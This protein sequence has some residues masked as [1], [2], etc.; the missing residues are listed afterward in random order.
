[1]TSANF[2]NF[3]DFINHHATY[4]DPTVLLVDLAKGSYHVLSFAN[5]EPKLSKINLAARYRDD[6]KEAQIDIFDKNHPKA[7]NVSDRQPVLLTIR[8][9][10]QE[11]SYKNLIFSGPVLKQVADV[12]KYKN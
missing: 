6:V 3:A 10:P 5:L 7:G 2:L 8:F 11:S 9:K 4:R 12:T 1:M